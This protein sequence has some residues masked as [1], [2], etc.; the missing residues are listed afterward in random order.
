M[1]AVANPQG[2]SSLTS[3]SSLLTFPLA[4][5]IRR[6]RTRDPV[7]GVAL[8]IPGGLNRLERRVEVGKQ[9]EKIQHNIQNFY[10]TPN[11]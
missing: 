3:P 1:A 11:T 2:G 6:Q 9:I 8:L 7:D 10:H 5:P 4:E